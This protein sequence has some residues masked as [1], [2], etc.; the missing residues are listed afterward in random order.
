VYN[1]ILTTSFINN[2]K[3][4]SARKRQS[5]DQFFSQKD[6]VGDAEKMHVLERFDQLGGPFI[7]SFI[8]SFF[9]CV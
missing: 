5:P 6:I 3:I 4:S 8:H 9:P 7:P 2:W 1:P